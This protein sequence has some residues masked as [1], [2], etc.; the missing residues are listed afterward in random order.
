[1]IKF[2]IFAFVFI[3][4]CGGCSLAPIKYQEVQAGKWEANVLI[5]DKV[6]HKSYILNFDIVAKRPYDV[7]IEM[8]TPLGMHVGSLTLNKDKI[9]YILPKEKRYYSGVPSAKSLKPILGTE[10]EPKLLV[11]L[12]FDLKPDAKVWSCESNKEG[13]LARCK[14]QRKSWIVEWKKRSGP[15]K[16]VFVKMKQAKIQLNFHTFEETS[17]IPSQTFVLTAPKGYKKFQLN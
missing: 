17:E 4:F 12:L 9:A 14:H 5:R 2:Q 15:R 6:K 7:R 16:S 11:N 8:T 10:F 3:A 1:L 13:F